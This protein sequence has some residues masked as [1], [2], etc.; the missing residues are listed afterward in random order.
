VLNKSGA[1]FSFPTTLPFV[2][3]CLLSSSKVSTN[4]D[5]L[6]G[7]LCLHNKVFAC[8]GLCGVFFLAVLDLAVGSHSRKRVGSVGIGGQLI[9]ILKMFFLP[10]NLLG[11]L[12]AQSCYMVHSG[13]NFF[14]AKTK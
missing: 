2:R 11:S 7:S 12:K 5:E 1:A 13:K 3:L 10:A 6:F 14:F 4:G 8:T 9:C